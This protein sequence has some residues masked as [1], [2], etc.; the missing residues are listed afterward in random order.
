MKF[1]SFLLISSLCI[2]SVI[3]A[4]KPVEEE[5]VLVL[6]VANF[7][8]TIAANKYLLVEF[9]KYFKSFKT[10]FTTISLPTFN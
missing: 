3:N 5:D 2:F 1:L 6:T 7:E 4:E 8:E 9:C 10:I